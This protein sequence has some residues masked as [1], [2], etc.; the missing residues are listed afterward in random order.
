[1]NNRYINE[2]SFDEENQEEFSDDSEYVLRN[3]RN[4][5]RY[6]NEDYMLRQSGMDSFEEE[7]NDFNENSGYLEPQNLN[8]NNAI[9]VNEQNNNKNVLIVN[10]QINSN[11]VLKKAKSNDTILHFQPK[12]HNRG[13]WG[14]T[15]LRKGTWLVIVSLILFVI[16]IVLV[17]VFWGLWYGHAVNYPLRVVAITL[18]CT[19]FICFVCGVLS[20]YLM[21]LNSNF[22]YFLG[23]PIRKCSYVLLSSILLLI[24]ASA[25]M[26]SYY[27]YWHNRW[28]NT[29]LIIISIVFFVF[30]G[31]MFYF[32]MRHNLIQFFKHRYEM[33][34]TSNEPKQLVKF[35]EKRSIYDDKLLAKR[36]IKETQ[37]VDQ[38][39]Q[40]NE[41]Q[42][43][44]QQEQRQPRNFRKKL[45]VNKSMPFT[46]TGPA[47]MNSTF[48][49]GQQN[50]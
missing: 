29:P 48:N 22:K 15:K 42:N 13:F 11:N 50:Q 41:Q 19:S 3:Q 2:P 45:T 12:I 40:Q 27:T 31:I 24:M 17:G 38:F 30:G 1:M 8:N 32:S 28:V 23:S 5:G 10:E 18:L 21:T 25:L 44:Q 47:P 46:T 14:K 16:A 9:I 20:N 4:S 35:H 6:I 39:N 7:P 33:Y 26:A 36:F 43:Q 49:E 37:E 34:K